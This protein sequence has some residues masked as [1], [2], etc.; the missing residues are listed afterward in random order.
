MVRPTIIPAKPQE[1]A[2]HECP[3]ELTALVLCRAAAPHII[4]DLAIA[5]KTFTELRTTIVEAGGVSS[6]TLA[7][8]LK[9]LESEGYVTRTALQGYRRRVEYSLSEK[10]RSLVPIVE[11]MKTFGESWL[12]ST[13]CEELS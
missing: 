1:T 13:D 4:R 3:V 11:A 9:S 10:G 7:A 6:R 5:P 8:R 12:L 2:P